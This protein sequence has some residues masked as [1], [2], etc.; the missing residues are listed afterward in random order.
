MRKHKASPTPLAVGVTGLADLLG[1]SRSHIY[2]LDGEGKL[3]RGIHLGGR[4]VW[5]VEQVRAW[6]ED[7]APRREIWE[8]RREN[9]R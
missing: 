8:A 7:G 1:V 5:S 2:R 3:P 4:K 9:R 6:L